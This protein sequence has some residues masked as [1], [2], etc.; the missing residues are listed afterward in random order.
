M[1][2]KGYL[3]VAGV[4]EN[5]SASVGEDGT[6]YAVFGSGGGEL[7]AEQ[8]AR[9]PAGLDP[10]RLSPLAERIVTET[11]PPVEMATCTARLLFKAAGSLNTTL[12]ATGHGDL[13]SD[14][15]IRTRSL[16]R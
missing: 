11:I 8:L 14:G 7:L 15:K 13:R 1:A 6:R 3:R 4:I 5:M 16:L 9:T 10:A 12:A 2:H